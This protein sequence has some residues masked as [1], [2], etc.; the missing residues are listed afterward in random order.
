VVW[1]IEGTDTIATLTFLFESLGNVPQI[2]WLPCILSGTLPPLS[3]SDLVLSLIFGSFPLF[4]V[5]FLGLVA[6][7]GV[8]GWLRQRW[9]IWERARGQ[10]NGRF[11]QYNILGRH[12]LPNGTSLADCLKAL[13]EAADDAMGRIGPAL[14]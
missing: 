6:W 13:K 10:A 5:L 3:A 12:T 4:G 2:S 11:M 8:S 14:S 1:F 9:S 7:I